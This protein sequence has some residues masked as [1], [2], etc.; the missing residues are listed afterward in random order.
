[1]KAEVTKLVYQ[2]LCCG[3]N[4]N[5]RV[6]TENVR[7]CLVAMITCHIWKLMFNLNFGRGLSDIYVTSNFKG[8][9]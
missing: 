4:F 6:A 3:S 2:S 1:M 9:K 5:V 7:E 8:Q